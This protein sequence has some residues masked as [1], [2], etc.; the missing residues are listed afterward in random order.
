MWAFETS[1]PA[2]SGTSPLPGIHLHSSQTS[3]PTWDLPN[4]QIYEA[5]VTFHSEPQ[6]GLNEDFFLCL[7]W[8]TAEAW[9]ILSL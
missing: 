6:H 8:V 4:S 5:L 9:E 7:L 1:M 2:S 3:L